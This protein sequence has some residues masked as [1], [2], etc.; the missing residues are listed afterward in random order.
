VK[1]TADDLAGEV[2]GYLCADCGRRW[3]AGPIDGMAV[4]I[5]SSPERLCCDG[6]AV[7]LPS[8]WRLPSGVDD[9][10]AFVAVGQ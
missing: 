4:V 9:V 8:S 5:Q 10:E 1:R 6:A 2:R 7:R 3:A